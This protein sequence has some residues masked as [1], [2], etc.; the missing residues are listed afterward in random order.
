MLTSSPIKK[1]LR[2]A[3]LYSFFAY[4]GITQLWVIYLSQM[5]LSLVQIG[6]CESIFHISSMLFEL[7]SGVLADRFTYKRMLN[8]SRVAALISSAMMLWQGGFWWFALSFVISAWSYNLQSGTLEALVFESLKEVDQ[9]SLYAKITS[10]MNSIIEVTSTGGLI[11][12]GLLTQGHMVW[13]YW[14]A[15]VLA[16]LGI[17]S[18][19]KMKEPKNHQDYEQ[20]NTIV[21]II[22]NAGSLVKNDRNLL[23][24]MLFD[25]VIQTLIS[26]YYYYFQNEMVVHNFP[27][28]LV[29][30]CLAGSAL[31]AVIA[32]SISPRLLK[33]PQRSLLLGLTTLLAVSLLAAF[34]GQKVVL[35][36]IFFI[37]YGI[38]ALI[39]PVFNVYYN[40]KIPSEQ[41]ATLLS[42]ASLI[43][44][45]TMVVMFPLMGWVVSKISFSVAFGFLGII[46]LL[47]TFWLAYLTRKSKTKA[48]N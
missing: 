40:E 35:G 36:I 20:T 32:I 13:A 29:T 31:A 7:P 26:T 44:S 1:Q 25:G 15:L 28:W 11:F 30:L 45:V 19:F 21:S 47:A 23:S 18:V 4:C 41:R 48:S 2:Y 22:K 17:F 14:I 3:Y 5:G 38:T 33:L 12:A 16:L 46:V 10:K 8:L 42:V 9:T 27:G 39:P 43:F 6:L 24:L 37:T 34:N